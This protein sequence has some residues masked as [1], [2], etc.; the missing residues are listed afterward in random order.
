MA[1]EDGEEGWHPTREIST[2]VVD[3]SPSNSSSFVCRGVDCK[4]CKFGHGF[5]AMNQKEKK[6]WPELKGKKNWPDSRIS[7]DVESKT[8][9]KTT[10]LIFKGA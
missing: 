9:T 1:A 2:P 5:W 6:N 3:L 4:I 10:R 7:W 8:G